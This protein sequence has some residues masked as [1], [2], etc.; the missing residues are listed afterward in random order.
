MIS[1]LTLFAFTGCNQEDQDIEV[2]QKDEGG[3]AEEG[4]GS[5]H[6][7]TWEH[8]C[9]Y[10]SPSSGTHYVQKKKYSYAFRCVKQGSLGA[11]KTFSSQSSADYH[12]RT[13]F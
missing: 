11:H 1:V 9:T 12:C 2:S 8:Y 7:G 10:N 6:S 13:G 3:P 5:G 4:D